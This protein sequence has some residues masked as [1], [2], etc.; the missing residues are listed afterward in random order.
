MLRLRLPRRLRA[1]V[2]RVVD[3]LVPPRVPTPPGAPPF[4]PHAPHLPPPERLP[5]DDGD[6]RGT[7]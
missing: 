3:A 2:R 6:N 1:V 7:L 5:G 4:D